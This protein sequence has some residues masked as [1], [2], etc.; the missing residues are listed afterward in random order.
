MG[1]DAMSGITVAIPTYN[2]GAILVETIERLL[3]L[4][5][6]ADEIVIVD[7]TPAHPPEIAAK[8]E[9]WARAG[10]IRWERLC[11]PSVPAAM[12][13]ALRIASQPVVLF[14]DDDLIPDSALAGV[15]LRA[16]GDGI[17]AVVGQVLQPGE[18]ER[19][20]EESHLH[21]G[22]VRD[23]DF[24]FSHD[25]ATDVENVMAGNLSV[26]RE[27]ALSIGGFDERFLYA[28]YR[29]ESDFARRVI[30]AGGRIRFEPAAK[31]R[32]LKLPTGG[33]RSH[34][35]PRRTPAPTHSAGDYLFAM[36]HV[37]SFWPYAA[38]RFRQNVFTRYTLAHPV[39]IPMKAI[40]EIRGLI[41]A[42]RLAR[43]ESFAP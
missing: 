22:A 20:F 37:P 32:H 11:Q 39:A 38:R 28:A 23:L 41:L 29:F 8:L 9:T 35:D 12:N 15:H 43:R 16:N 14:L 36:K 21:R 33:V 25:V 5:P 26:V 6:K 3:A 31:I 13:H 30:A 10:Q 17:W 18:E 7:Q 2:R 1:E 4:E 34:G 40:A 19:H 24:P 42:R 27:R